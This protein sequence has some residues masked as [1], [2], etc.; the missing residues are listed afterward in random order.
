MITS[1]PRSSYVESFQPTPATRTSTASTTSTNSSFAKS[2]WFKAKEITDRAHQDD[3]TSDTA[4][5]DTMTR[6]QL[7]EYRR[8]KAE[9]KRQRRQLAKDM[10][11]S[12]WLE[13]VDE[14]HR[15]GS[16]LR[17]YHAVWKKA[18]TNENFFQW[19][20]HGEG[21]RVNTEKCSRE[22]LDRDQV[23]YLTREQRLQY[24]VKFDEQGRLRWAK[25]GERVE[26]SADYIDDGTGIVRRPDADM[27]TKAPQKENSKFETLK[28][29][30]RIQQ[31]EHKDETDSSDSELAGG[32]PQNGRRK[33]TV[34]PAAIFD[35]LT[36]STSSGN[37][38]KKP[39]WIFV[40]DTSFRLYV[41]MKV[42]SP[43]HIAD[44]TE[45]TLSPRC[46]ARSSTPHSFKALEYP[47]LVRSESRMV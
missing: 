12:Y 1:R 45:L 37:A 2:Q 17:A 33:T 14:K 39:K 11:L 6:E 10:G 35:E 42:V 31:D 24:L 5:D 4:D 21:L 3:T 32:R 27:V 19:L 25:N 30:L 16:H 7:D 18:D 38:K 34:P 44:D 43:S 29:K 47:L 46:P 8:K 22:V 13:M 40:A 9:A 26:T 15:Y 23:R 20:D 36:Q 28:Q 41:G